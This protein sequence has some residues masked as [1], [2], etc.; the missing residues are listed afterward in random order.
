MTI[1]IKK[2]DLCKT[3]YRNDEE[4]HWSDCVNK[5]ILDFKNH[6]GVQVMIEQDACT[7]CAR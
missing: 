2:C 3:E 1:E 5:I 6:A 4:K 7:K